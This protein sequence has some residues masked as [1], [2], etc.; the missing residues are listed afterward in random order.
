L[1]SKQN[2][3]WKEKNRPEFLDKNQQPEDK[4]QNDSL[5]ACGYLSESLTKQVCFLSFSAPPTTLPD[6]SWQVTASTNVSILQTLLQGRKRERHYHFIRRSLH[7][8]NALSERWS[9]LQSALQYQ[10]YHNIFSTSNT[11]TTD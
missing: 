6:I 11:P 7:L 9:D 10:P 5:M 3:P 8:V 1:T 4:M 2:H